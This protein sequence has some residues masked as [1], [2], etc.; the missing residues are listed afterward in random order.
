MALNHAIY[1]VL[2]VCL[3]RRNHSTPKSV[4]YNTVIE[5]KWV[6]HGLKKKKIKTKLYLY[7]SNSFKE[8]NRNL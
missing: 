4:D 7:L 2:S 3:T 8:N 1:L 5:P 6:R